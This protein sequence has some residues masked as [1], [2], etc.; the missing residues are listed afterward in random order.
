[1]P[2]TRTVLSRWLCPRAL[3]LHLS[4]VVF[5][6][7]CLVAG[8]WQLHR[9]LAGN[10]LSWAYTFEWP[11]LAVL[12]TICWWQLIH[13]TPE[14]LRRR[15]EERKKDREEWRAAMTGQP[16]GRRRSSEEEPASADVE[17]Q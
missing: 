8:W 5:G 4:L 15:R 12:A 13:D 6:G 10:T 16:L 14:Q 3:G 11:M 17:G 7:I 2:Y 9:A 1:M